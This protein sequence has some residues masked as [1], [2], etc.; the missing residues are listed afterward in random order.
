MFTTLDG[1]GLAIRK[2]R[3]HPHMFSDH[4]WLQQLKVKEAE[5]WNLLSSDEKLAF[6]LLIYYA[7]VCRYVFMEISRNVS[8]SS[9]LAQIY[10]IP[11]LDIY[12]VVSLF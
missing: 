1:G 9:F 2:R 4:L 8:V 6:Y 3:P 7:F 11:F 5:F 10:V 12:T